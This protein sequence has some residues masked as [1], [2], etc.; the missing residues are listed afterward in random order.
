MLNMQRNNI[1]CKFAQKVKSANFI[2]LFTLEVKQ[3]KL[4]HHNIERYT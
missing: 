4:M 3:G 2:E 1:S